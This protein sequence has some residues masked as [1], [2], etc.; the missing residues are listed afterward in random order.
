MSQKLFSGT[1]TYQKV[2]MWTFVEEVEQLQARQ[3]SSGHLQ[4]WFASCATAKEK[5]ERGA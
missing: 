2:L 5:R 1:I 4:W 3:R